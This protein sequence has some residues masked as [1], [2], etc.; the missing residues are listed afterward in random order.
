MPSSYVTLNCKATF[1]LNTGTD[2]NTG[3]SILK[4]V[5]IT[6]VN[7]AM[8]AAQFQTVADKVNPLFA[9]PVISLAKTESQLVETV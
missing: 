2:P 6:G 9:H 7:P 5:P 4:S 1:S 8:T 3:K